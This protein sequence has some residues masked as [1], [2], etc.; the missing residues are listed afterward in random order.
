MQWH[1]N[2]SR[3]YVFTVKFSKIRA[4]HPAPTFAAIGDNRPPNRESLACKS[5]AGFIELHPFPSPNSP[6]RALFMP[7]RVLATRL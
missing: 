7:F 2:K 1:C 4:I 3:P 5:W 6:V